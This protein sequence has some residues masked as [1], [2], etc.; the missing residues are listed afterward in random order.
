MK[1]P[2]LQVIA[3]QV[4]T[5]STMLTI[6]LSAQ[7]QKPVYQCHGIY[8]DKPCAGGREVDIR[9]TEG[10]H[11][12]SGNRKQSQ[13]AAIRDLT[14]N[15][16]NARHEGVRQGMAIARCNQLRQERIRIDSG[17]PTG[18]LEGRRLAVRQEQFKLGCNKT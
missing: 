4:F 14:R 5:V 10:A 8:T 6:A 1:R 11:S 7:A 15:M 9:P 16:D 13:E 18:D 3:R 12:M 2:S 17:Q